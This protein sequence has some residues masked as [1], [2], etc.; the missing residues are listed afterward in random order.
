M[1]TENCKPLVSICIPVY[2]NAKYLKETLISILNQTYENTEIIVG[3]NAS[4]E[5]IEEVLFELGR[6]K[7]TYYKNETNLGYAGN[8]NKLISMAKGKYIAIYHGDDI[9]LPYIIEEEVKALEENKALGAVFSLGKIMNAEGKESKVRKL[10]NLVR[11]IR[12]KLIANKKD[13][14]GNFIIDLDTYIKFICKMHNILMTPT[15]MVRKEVYKELNGYN[16]NLRIIDDQDMWSRILEKHNIIIINK[17]LF[18]YR[19]HQNQVSTHYNSLERSELS[20]YLSYFRNYI[21][22]NNII[23]RKDFKKAF[24]KKIAKE[25][26]ELMKKEIRKYLIR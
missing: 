5:N 19:I 22:S 4:E 8:C 18:K 25:Y 20:V 11:N 21:T 15:S 3:D 2:N 7:F 24:N 13:K 6:E 16:A 10:R 23:L 14:K 12:I 26:N 9:Y 1:N 17:E